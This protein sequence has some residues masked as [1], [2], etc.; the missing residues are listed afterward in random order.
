MEY[1]AFLRRLLCIMFTVAYST[2]ILSQDCSVEKETLKGSYTGECKNGKAN[3]KGKAT[4]TDTYDGEFRSGQPD[5]QGTYTWSNGNSYSGKFSK[6]QRD[7]KGTMYY[8]RT[9]AADSIIDGYWKKDAYIGKFEKPYT[10]YFK[11]KAV[12]EVEIELK[13]NTFKQITFFINSTSGGAASLD[14]TEMPKMKVDDI[15]VI[16]GSY[17][18][19][20]SNSNNSKKTEMILYDV[21]FPVRMKVSMGNEQIE[22]EFNEEG[23]YSVNV[24]IN[25]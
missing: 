14:G 19:T 6:G 17:G 16:K 23:S 25:Q 9:N 8:K 4:G 12:T 18:R 24:R 15:Q 20:M 21:N 10:V 13:K 5:G 22:V 2:I 7:G 11:S 1:P 3:G